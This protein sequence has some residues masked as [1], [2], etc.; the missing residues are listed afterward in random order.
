MNVYTNNM[1]QAQLNALNEVVR[2]T[3]NDGVYSVDVTKAVLESGTPMHRL[4][5]LLSAKII[6]LLV[7]TDVQ[8]SSI[9]QQ[10]EQTILN[11]LDAIVGETRSAI[12]AY[13][14]SRQ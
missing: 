1:N 6:D 4:L 11:S 5:D 12:I 7:F 14:K 8:S 9:E 3:A 2:R 10:D 13:Q